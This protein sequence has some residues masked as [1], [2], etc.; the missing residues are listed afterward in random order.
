MLLSKTREPDE[1]PTRRLGKQSKRSSDDIKNIKKGGLIK[2]EWQIVVA[3][4]IAI[5]IILFPVV[6]V[7][8]LNAGGIYA[9]IK[10]A[11]ARRAVHEKRRGVVAEAKQSITVDR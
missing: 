5:P 9:A 3:L 6:F 2:M 8:Y 11:R 4:V 10:E 7:W 1:M